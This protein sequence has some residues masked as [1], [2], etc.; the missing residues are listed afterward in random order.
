MTTRRQRRLE[1]TQRT[2]SEDSSSGDDAERT[3]VENSEEER[4]LLSIANDTEEAASTTNEDDDIIIDEVHI[5]V[6]AQVNTKKAN[7]NGTADINHG[8]NTMSVSDKVKRALSV[9]SD[10]SPSCSTLPQDVEM[11]NT[12]PT[13]NN[14]AKEDHVKNVEKEE[15]GKEDRDS[16]KTEKMAPNE[17]L[18]IPSSSKDQVVNINY[19]DLTAFIANIATKITNGNVPPSAP[20]QEIIKFKEPEVA[21]KKQEVQISLKSVLLKDTKKCLLNI[22][23]CIYTFKEILIFILLHHS[24]WLIKLPNFC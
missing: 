18:A 17:L 11:Q 1:E 9:G 8:L 12:A 4:Q 14:D 23:S 19:A 10:G 21:A 16:P 22:T 15:E 24:K 3:V 13:E 2:L 5:A 7:S 6:T 20:K